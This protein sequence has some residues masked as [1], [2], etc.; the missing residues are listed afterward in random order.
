[1]QR[2]TDLVVMIEESFEHGGS[3]TRSQWVM[4]W[5]GFATTLLVFTGKL[6]WK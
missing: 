3:K 6:V 4:E 5:E 1:M 2:G